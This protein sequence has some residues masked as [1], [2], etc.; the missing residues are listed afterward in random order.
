MHVRYKP[1]FDQLTVYGDTANE[2]KAE[3]YFSDMTRG[4]V[5]GHYS[6]IFG[7]SGNA[8]NPSAA[9]RAVLDPN[10]YA[11][12]L[13]PAVQMLPL[14]EHYIDSATLITGSAAG[15]DGNEYVSMTA[16]TG[17]IGQRALYLNLNHF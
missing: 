15:P 7:P 3:G 4:L 12:S 10:Y 11:D 2:R 9:R 8:F 6:L 16:F 1:L 14:Q 5:D 13:L 17:T